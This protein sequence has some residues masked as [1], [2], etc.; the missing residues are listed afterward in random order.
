[1]NSG[2]PNNIDHILIYFESLVLR[3]QFQNNLKNTF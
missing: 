1:M 2:V 3:K